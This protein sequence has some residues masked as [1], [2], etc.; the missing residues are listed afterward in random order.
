MHS[1][2]SRGT[3]T[4]GASQ[5]NKAIL[6]VKQA[7]SYLC[8]AS[9]ESSSC[10]HGRV[11]APLQERKARL[12]GGLSCSWVS[13]QACRMSCMLSRR[14]HTPVEAGTRAHARPGAQATE[15]KTQCGLSASDKCHHVDVS[16]GSL[17][18]ALSCFLLLASIARTPPASSLLAPIVRRIYGPFSLESIL[19]PLGERLVHEVVLS[20]LVGDLLRSFP[21][22][23]HVLR[24]TQIPVDQSD[25]CHRRRL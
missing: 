2:A 8:G 1:R 4:R 17:L 6:E 25:E 16:L 21:A 3:H 14:S 18:L 5:H 19:D 13:R 12:A 22:R 20:H 9:D 7:C 24:V 10:P 15:R 23:H 11:H